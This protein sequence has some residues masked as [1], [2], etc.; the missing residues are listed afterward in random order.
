M[1][2]SWLVVNNRNLHSS[3]ESQQA[4]RAAAAE[5]RAEYLSQADQN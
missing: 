2:L 4:I 1:R 3:E 5:P